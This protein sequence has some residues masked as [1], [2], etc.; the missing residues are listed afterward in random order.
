MPVK[1]LNKSPKEPKS[2]EGTPQVSDGGVGE[3]LEEGANLQTGGHNDRGTNFQLLELVWALDWAWAGT[4]RGL[5]KM[6][7]LE[8]FS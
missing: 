5:P 8:A 6:L 1:C 2:H 7:S 3:I 4:F